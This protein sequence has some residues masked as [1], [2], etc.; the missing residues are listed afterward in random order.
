IM[1]ISGVGGAEVRTKKTITITPVLPT[2]IAIS[3]SAAISG[4]DLSLAHTTTPAR[5][6]DP[7]VSWA[8]VSAGATGATL[9]GNVLSTSAVGTVRV[10]ATS[11]AANPDITVIKDISVNNVPSE[12]VLITSHNVVGDGFSLE[13]KSEL[14]KQI[15]CLI[16]LSFSFYFSV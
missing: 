7:S 8:I 12:D 16:C 9:A 1:I 3:S 11:T 13:L 10:S 2:A 4:V 6:S 14:I 5:V 15:I